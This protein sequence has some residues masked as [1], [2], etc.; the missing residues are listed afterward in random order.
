MV[1]RQVS[2]P[3]RRDSKSDRDAILR[4]NRK[5]GHGVFN[6]GHRC[7][8]DLTHRISSCK[9]R[10]SCAGAITNLSI[11]SQRNQQY[12]TTALT[13]SGGSITERYAYSAYGVP[14]ITD[15]SGTPRS[16]TA[17]GNRYT[18]TGREWDDEAE[19][20]HV[21]A[22]WFDLL[23]GR[24][25]SRHPIGFEGSRWSLQEYG[26]GRPLVTIDPYGREFA[27]AVGAGVAGADAAGTVIFIGGAAIA[28]SGTAICSY[29][30]GRC[31][32][33]CWLIPYLENMSSNRP[34]IC[35]AKDLPADR[36]A[37]EWGRRN[38]IDPR[39]AR[40]RFHEQKK[41]LGGK[42]V[43]RGGDWTVDPCSGNVKSGNP[44]EV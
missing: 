14:M 16:S 15:A 44:P 28:I 33:E 37:E 20:Y 43:S 31:A 18:N 19:L 3:I 10:H 40:N 12:S 5:T 26:G 42:S 32:S 24:F 13:N 22:R 34:A 11:R 17:E 8:S 21:R 30:A 4:A 25:C 2:Y 9:T 7:R 36:G 29:E 27:T 35:I 23:S 38:G 1:A 41:K 39:E 6:S